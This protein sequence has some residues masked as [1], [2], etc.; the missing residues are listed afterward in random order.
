MIVLNKDQVSALIDKVPVTEALRAMFFELA[1]GKAVQPAQ[2]LCPFPDGGDFITYLGAQPHAGVF[3]AKLSPYLPHPGGAHVTAW[4]LLMSA[5]T[6]EPV[7]LCDSSQLTTERTAGTTALAVD[8]LAPDDAETL[9]IIGTGKTALAHYRH[10][11]TLRPWQSIRFY[12]PGIASRP[13]I[14]DLAKSDP[15][16]SLHTHCEEAFDQADAILLCTSSGLPVVDVTMITWPAIITSISTNA[17]N[18][19]EIAPSALCDLDVYCDYR[20]TAPTTAGEMR[21]AIAANIW[22]SDQ[23]R[24]DLGELITGKAMQPSRN[25]PVF[26]RSVGL[27]LEDIAV[28]TALLA[29][30]TADQAES[31]SK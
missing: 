26:F 19:H 21:L 29:T 20:P 18:A 30:S 11:S 23:I 22:S 7:L 9:A 4:T 6:G 31:H 1:E 2:L 12:S 8:L 24:G 10:V 3:G 17:V 28:A 5:T 13:D 15:R 27:G 16:I 25:R 14:A